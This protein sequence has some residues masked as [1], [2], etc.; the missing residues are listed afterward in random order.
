ME[1]A[2]TKE[3]YEYNPETKEFELIPGS[4][5]NVVADGL[6][7]KEAVDFIESNAKPELLTTVDIPCNDSHE[8]FLGFGLQSK[9]DRN[10]NG[11]AV[12]EGHRVVHW[13]IIPSIT[14][15]LED[16]Q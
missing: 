13:R 11:K 7:M 3:V 8:R 16:K 9:L 14:P 1:Y 12:A 6:T 10:G 5:D 2:I 4:V 15:G